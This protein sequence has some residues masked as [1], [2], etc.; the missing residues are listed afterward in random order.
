MPQFPALCFYVRFAQMP[1]NRH[2]RS[3]ST[4]CNVIW[5]FYIS[6]TVVQISVATYYEHISKAL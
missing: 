1:W 6:N 5:H 4:F 3:A 2:E